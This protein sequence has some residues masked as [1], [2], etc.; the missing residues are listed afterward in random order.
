[1]AKV[2]LDVPT[3]AQE[4]SMCC[5]HTSAMM[6]WFYWRQQTG[7]LGPMN[8]LGPT[9]AANTGLPPNVQALITLGKTTGLK[10]LPTK[11]AYSSA[12]IYATLKQCGPLWCAGTWYG[13]GHVI[14]LTGVDGGTV[15]LNDPDKGVKKDGTL[16]WFNKKLMNSLAGCIMYHDPET[17]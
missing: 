4:K 5:W 2:L 9:Y 3:L 7:R 8:T 12:D 13:F 15:F 11:N 17:Y 14:V 10:A 1:M 16:D 6:I